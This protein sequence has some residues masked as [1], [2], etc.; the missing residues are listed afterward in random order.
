M[1]ATAR[2]LEINCQ[3]IYIPGVML[4]SFGDA[5]THTS[6]IKV[7]SGECTTHMT[8]AD[9]LAHLQFLKQAN[10]L[11]LGKLL[12]AYL[13]YYNVIYDKISVTEA[14]V[15]L[16]ELMVA[17]PKYS[18]WQNMIIGACASAFI[19]PSG[20]SRL[21][22]KLR[23]ELIIIMLTL[24]AFYGSFIDCLVAMPL[25]A[26]LV[27]VQVVVSRNDLYSSLFE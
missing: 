21:S 14:S 5:A 24:T 17:G 8:R 15:E 18:L 16:D 1:Q 12:A 20:Q 13:V 2:V 7:C 6:D 10:G 9:Q 22:D 3:V 23:L 27:L 19:Q 26:M 25:G 4:I 11:D